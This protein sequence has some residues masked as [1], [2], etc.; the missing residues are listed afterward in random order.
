MPQWASPPVWKSNWYEKGGKLK[1]VTKDI[2]L[3]KII[4]RSM[5]V[6]IYKSREMFEAVQVPI[7]GCIYI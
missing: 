1:K 3:K 5:Y 7:S 2:V 6:V 4:Y